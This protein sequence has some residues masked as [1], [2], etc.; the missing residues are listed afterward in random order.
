MH[1]FLELDMAVS[2]LSCRYDNPLLFLHRCNS[3]GSVRT[4]Y[5]N[6][7]SDPLNLT[8][9]VHRGF[10]VMNQDILH[11]YHQFYYYFCVYFF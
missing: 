1:L 8:C 3:T 4:G 5:F 6:L 7:H 11:F 9:I 10:I 2:A